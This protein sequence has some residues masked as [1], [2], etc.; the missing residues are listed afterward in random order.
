MFYSSASYQNKINLLNP[1]YVIYC[2]KYG[3][4]IVTAHA[5]PITILGILL[6]KQLIFSARSLSSRVLQT[7]ALFELRYFI[8]ETKVRRYGHRGY[9]F[10]ALM[11][12][13]IGIFHPVNAYR[14]G[15][16]RHE[17]LICADLHE[18]A[19]PATYRYLLYSYCCR[20]YLKRCLE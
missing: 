7:I 2:C 19:D 8:G 1:L 15:E 10:A 20:Y 5:L 16:R 9:V 17:I 3:I 12:H 18:G 14:L 13:K 11:Q 6:F 4:G